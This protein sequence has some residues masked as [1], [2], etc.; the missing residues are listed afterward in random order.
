MLLNTGMHWFYGVAIE[1]GILAFG[2]GIIRGVAAKS[3]AFNAILRG[4]WAILIG[5]GA[6]WGPIL[7]KMIWNFW[8]SAAFSLTA[9]ATRDN[10]RAIERFLPGSRA[11]KACCKGDWMTQSPKKPDITTGG[12]SFR[13]TRRYSFSE[14]D[15]WDS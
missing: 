11:G 4:Y 5:S 8:V 13:S 10:K 14:M 2:H 7:L 9:L 12:K 15:R 3:D 1:N 6:V